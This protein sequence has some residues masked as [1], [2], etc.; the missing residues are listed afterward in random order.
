MAKTRTP[1]KN[2]RNIRRARAIKR[3]EASIPSIKDP[4]KLAA[5]KTVL[6]NSKK[7]QAAKGGSL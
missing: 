2:K 5:A 1:V 7:I 4:S 3:L 6:E